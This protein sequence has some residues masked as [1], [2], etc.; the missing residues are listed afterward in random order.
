MGKKKGKKKD[1]WSQ[2]TS[3]LMGLFGAT[4]LLHDAIPIEFIVIFAVAA[5]FV[6]YTVKTRKD[7]DMT[8]EQ[9]LLEYKTRHR[10][11]ET[12]AGRAGESMWGTLDRY[13]TD[14]ADQNS[15]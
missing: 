5:A 13:I 4:I 8:W 12:D 7:E 10:L 11:D 1:R 3:A 6:W 14:A 15:K 2:I 9:M